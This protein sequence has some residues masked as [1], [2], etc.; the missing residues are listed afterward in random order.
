MTGAPA[1]RHHKDADQMRPVAECQFDGIGGARFADRRR[2]NENGDRLQRHG[3]A[4]LQVHPKMHAA[5]LLP[6]N[7]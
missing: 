5:L 7:N 1:E 4:P 6:G 3:K 2:I